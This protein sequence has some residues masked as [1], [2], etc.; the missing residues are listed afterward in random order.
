MQSFV[1]QVE[2]K[3]SEGIKK[4]GFEPDRV[5]LSNSNKPEL[6]QFQ[7]NGIMAIAKRNGK[8]PVELANSL[9]EILKEDTCFKSLS[10]AG[11]GFINIVFDDAFLV[12]YMN[13]CLTDFDNFIDV[14]ELSL[15]KIIDKLSKSTL[16]SSLTLLVT[17]IA[18]SPPSNAI[19]GSTLSFNVSEN[20][21]A[22][23]TLTP[24]AL[25]T[26]TTLLILN[27][28]EYFTLTLTVLLLVSTCTFVT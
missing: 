2:N 4:L 16:I 11:P 24:F 18:V 9:V 17:V 19:C 10:V 12:N 6:G 15:K 23:S 1:K 14:E 8:N 20:A 3:I 27:T 21:F 7:F 5:L 26:L 25:L 22:L 28:F 13:Q